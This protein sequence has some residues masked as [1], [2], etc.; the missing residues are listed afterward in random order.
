M[1]KRAVVLL[2]LVSCFPDADKLR[3]GGGTGPVNTG[4]GGGTSVGGAGGGLAGAGGAGG[5]LAGTGG[6]AGGAGGAVGNRAQLCNE[7]AVATAAKAHECTPF[8]QALRYG[9]QAAQAARIRL[10]CNIYELPSVRFPPS[11]FQP[12]AEALA[13]QACSD[14]IDGAFPGACLGSGELAV[15]ATCASGFQCQSDL[16][17]I[18]AMGCG[19]CATLPGAGQP[20]YEGFCAAGLVCN[21]AGSCVA[22]GR[23][24][25]TCDANSPCAASLGCHLGKCG[26]LGAPGAPCTNFDECD[27]YHGSFCPTMGTRCVAVVVGPTCMNNPDGSRGACGAGGTCRTDGTCVPAAP[28][29]AACSAESGPNCT[30]PAQCLSD[31]QCHLFQ[32]NRTCLGSAAVR[33]AEPSLALPSPE[34]GVAAFWR[35]LVP[36]PPKP[37]F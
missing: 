35:S 20:C 15:G 3:K 10:N 31:N 12:C 6:A 5:N 29:G 28:D 32:P 9:S 8:L 17:D 22:P 18:P 26:T 16:C 11:P 1:R 36:R 27:I 33:P 14:W 7:L 30:W 23:A 4:T 34:I 21:M 25:A 13:A 37:N 19:K 24:G 2:L